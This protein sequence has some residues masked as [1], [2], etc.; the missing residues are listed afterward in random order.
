MLKKAIPLLP[1]VNIR[2]TL[3]F[4][5]AKLGFAGINYGSYAML[6]Y[7]TTEIHLFM[8]KEK[9]THASHGCLI[10][11]DNIEDLY[12]T[13]SAKGLIEVKGKLADKPW[14]FKEFTIF[15]NNNNMIRFAQKRS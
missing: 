1:A 13:L 12:A 3:D 4:Y 15:D 10:M 11:V 7:K 9:T 6:K 8:A 2:E 5:E 14:G